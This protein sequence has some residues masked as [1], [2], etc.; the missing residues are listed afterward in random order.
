M[1]PTS[2][3]A[4]TTFTSTIITIQL[5]L[6]GLLSTVPTLSKTI[7]FF[8]PQMP[9]RPK[10]DTFPTTFLQNKSYDITYSIPRNS[11]RL[12]DTEASFGSNTYGVC[13]RI[14]IMH[15]CDLWMCE[16]NSFIFLI[17]LNN[18]EIVWLLRKMVERFASIPNLNQHASPLHW[19]HVSVCNRKRSTTHPSSCTHSHILR[20]HNHYNTMLLW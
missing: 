9:H 17:I 10:Y 13:E 11:Q 14:W 15:M 12:R 3:S 1:F 2:V 5:Y 20:R 16:H 18:D 7:L 19:H 8:M 4:L 6:S